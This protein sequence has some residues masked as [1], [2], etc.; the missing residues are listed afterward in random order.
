[1]K[2]NYNQKK[3]FIWLIIMAAISLNYKKG[4]ALSKPL[5]ALQKS[6]PLE[7]ITWKAEPEDRIFNNETIFDYIDGAGEVYR[8]YDMQHCLS[9]RYKMV[10]NPDIILDIFDMGSS[11]NA[12]G[13]FTHDQDGEESDIGQGALYRYGW[14]RFW[15]D[16]YFVSIYP[17]EETKAS[18]MAVMGLGKTVASIIKNKGSKPSILS[19]LPVNG[20]RPESIR[21]LH[22]SLILNYH[23]YLSDQNILFLGSETDVVLAEYHR[24]KEKAILL[25]AMYPSPDRAME[26]HASFLKNYM[27]DLDSNGIA[28]L[29]NGKWATSQLKKKI[30]IL[31]LEADSSSFAEDLVGEVIKSAPD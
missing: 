6:L 8:S 7:L 19:V 16:N 5:D 18:K 24:G 12:F 14:L 21:Y 2:W 20:L 10:N 3:L 30:V 26:A 22:D 1:M 28:D 4:S 15:K 17:E 11:E 29:E 9:R 23:Y 25:I 31:V 13:I 27:P